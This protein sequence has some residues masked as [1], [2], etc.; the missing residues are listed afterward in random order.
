L[1]PKQQEEAASK[2]KEFVES[3]E[4]PEAISVDMKHQSTAQIIYAENRVIY[5]VFFN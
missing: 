1:L 5:I 2:H 4:V 3:E